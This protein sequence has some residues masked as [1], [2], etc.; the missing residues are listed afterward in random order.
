[1]TLEVG[2]ITLAYGR[3]RVLHG[4]DLPP[5]AA[6]T[7]T[8][9]VGPNAA[10]KSSLLRAIA[11][12]M[13]FA[14]TARLGGMDLAALGRRL[15]SRRVAYL[16]Q[17]LP[18]R[19]NLSV[20]EAILLAAKQDES[21]RVSEAD[22]ALVE[23]VLVDLG[24]AHLAGRGLNELSGGQAQMV[25]LAQALVRRP[26]VLLLDEPTSALDLR[27]QL[28]V[29]AHVGRVT[30]AHGTIVLAALHDLNLAARFADL[31][32]VLREGRLHG[33]GTPAEVL[34]PAMLSEVYGVEAEVFRTADGGL[35]VQPL[36]PLP[37]RKPKTGPF[38]VERAA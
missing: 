37:R 27:H 20:V 21:L 34:T 6:G 5:L 18:G 15:A 25:S 13:R 36:R 29:L 33:A 4:I 3:T 26:E 8:A 31:V 17:E 22:L 16:P 10:G 30:Q 38:A 11:G 24:I 19:A 1:M 32:L 12:Q 9:L 35:V 28:E 2:G 7:V 23:G 14:G